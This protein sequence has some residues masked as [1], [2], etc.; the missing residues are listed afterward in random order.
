MASKEPECAQAG[1]RSGE[2]NKMHQLCEVTMIFDEKYENSFFFAF[3][4]K[5]IC[6]YEKK[7]VILWRS[8]KMVF[9]KN[10]KK[11]KIAF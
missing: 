2:E 1:G 6:K 10:N 11:C 7:S 3:S 9:Y 8:C 5:I 4:S